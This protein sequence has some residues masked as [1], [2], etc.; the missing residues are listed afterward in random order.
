MFSFKQ[1][2][3]SYTNILL[4]FALVFAITSGAYA[5]S[6]FVITSTKQIKPSVLKQLRGKTG[7]P[8]PTG[9]AAPAG[10]AGPAGAK[11]EPGVA[12][13]D[14]AH[15][16]E[17]KEGPQG[18]EGKAGSPW[19]AGGTLPKGATETGAW[20]FAGGP[21][22]SVITSISF[23]LPL[24]KALGAA[25][26]HYVEATGNGTTCQGSLASP[27]A[28]AGNLCVY[29]GYIAG[30][31]NEHPIVP[32][33]QGYLLEILRKEAV[34]EGAGVSG[35]ILVFVKQETERPIVEGT[36]AVTEGE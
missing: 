8:G 11:G 26:V 3:V 25:K 27:A 35:A 29:Q 2:R 13:K 19:T 34:L 1:Q 14:G 21:E 16:N 31:T 4:V 18:K 30:V 32:N 6:K 23:T 10:P 28:E 9:P 5:A 7:P 33:Y 15:G 20:S 12:G 17:G 36:W 24:A 22:G